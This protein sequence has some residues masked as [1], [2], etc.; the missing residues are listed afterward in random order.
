[1]KSVKA[2]DDDMVSVRKSVKDFCKK[3]DAYKYNKPFFVRRS[4]NKTI[5]FFIIKV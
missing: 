1:M 5:P 4:S 3:S 2:Y